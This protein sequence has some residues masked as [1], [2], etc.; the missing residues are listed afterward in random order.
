MYPILEKVAGAIDGF[1]EFTGRC[2]A[3]LIFVMVV[4]TFAIVMLR[5]G[6]QI[7]SIAM[8]EAAAYLHAIVFMVGVGYTLKHDEHVRV[9]IFYER[10]S[11]KGRALVDL[12]GTL[13]LMLPVCL[14]IAYISVDYISAS[15]RVREGS[16]NVGGLDGIYLIKTVI[17]FMTICLAL[18][19]MSKIIRSWLVF[20][21][22]TRSVEP[23][24]T[25][26]R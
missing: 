20:V 22:Y 1:S 21:G 15:W 12:L 14:F 17:W 7:G 3:W 25:A 24:D 19:G 16:R 2:L 26:T 13:F 9:D 18:Q 6:F 5:Y 11:E 10:M 4:L 23:L 8:Q